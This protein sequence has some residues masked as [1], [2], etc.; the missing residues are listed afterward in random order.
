MTA[1]APFLVIL[2]ILSP[3]IIPAAITAF[4]YLTGRAGTTSTQERL[5]ANFPRR[6]PAP[7]FAAA[8]A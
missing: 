3:V 7:R 6:T 8:A 4:H 2:L 1:Y 5:A